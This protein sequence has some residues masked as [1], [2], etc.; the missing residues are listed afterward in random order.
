M[1]TYPWRR[2]GQAVATLL[3]VI[4]LI[5]VIQRWNSTPLFLPAQYLSFMADVLRLDFGRSLAQNEAVLGVIVSRVPYTLALAGGAL[6]VAAAIGI[7][8]GAALARG[9]RHAVAGPLSWLLLAAQSMPVFW[10]GILLVMVS[11]KLAWLPPSSTG[12]SQLVIPAIALGL[13]GTASVARITRG[14]LLE[15]WST[16]EVRVAPVGPWWRHM[17]R[18]ASGPMISG[19]ELSALLT[20]IVVIEA[21]L[22]WPGLGQ[23]A[24]KAVLQRDF[25]V[26]RGLALLGA[27]VAIILHLAVDLL[28]RAADPR[29]PADDG[30]TVSTGVDTLASRHPSRRP[31]IALAGLVLTAMVIVAIFAPFIA[32]FDPIAQN[33]MGRLK[34]PGTMAGELHYLLGSDDLGRDLFSRLIWGARVSLLVAFVSLALSVVVGTLLGALA[35]YLRVVG[36]II[37]RLVD[38]FRSVPAIL[39][40]LM[41]LA[42]IGPSLEGLI[43]VLVL[44]LWPRYARVAYARIL[45]FRQADVVS[46]SAPTETS[47]APVRRR[48]LPGVLG[49]VL[50][51]ATLDLGFVVLFESSLSF[52]GLGAQPPAPSWGAM[53]SQGA[54]YMGSAWWIVVLP[55]LCLFVLVFFANLLGDA[56]R[57]PAAHQH[58]AER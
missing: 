46:S 13:M 6:L 9:R 16:G 31:V 47:T 5:Y 1:H 41:T 18:N 44:T 36:L 54:N 15:K 4:T 25:P 30:I 11:V 49:A 29:I 12:I 58:R 34:P 27:M 43:V 10:S 53:L 48:V 39:L 26:V 51:A 8:L 33:L 42:V 23:L 20:G 3:G 57:D 52:L 24:V 2:L 7:P 17:S 56:L 35:A 55:G 38:V 45:L 21:L 40:A 19:L 28:Q 50:V 32:P 22:A 37:M 14:I